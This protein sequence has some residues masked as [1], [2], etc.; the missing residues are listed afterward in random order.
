M[1]D[2]LSTSVSGLLAFQKALN[3]TSNNISNVATP[4]YSVENANFTEQP[5]QAFS[6]GYIGSGVNVQSVTRAYDEL[7][8]GQVRSSQSSYSSFNTYATQASQID[9]MLSDSSTGLTASLQSFVNA[10]QTVANSPSS[11]AQRQVLLSQAQSLTQQMQNYSSQ[12][13]TYSAGVESQIS[14]SVTQIN[15]LSAGIANLNGQIATGLASTGQ[16]PNS[17]MDQRDQMIDQLSQYV[18]V[19]TATQADGSMNVYIGSGQPL[20]TG[21][22]ST[23]LSAIQD[24]YNASVHDIG[25]ATGGGT[26]D[27]TSNISGGSLGGLL[28][29]RSQVLQPVQNTLGQF[30]V[31]LASI[32]NQAQQAGMDL[33]GAAGKPMFAVGPVLTAPSSAN[34]GTS[35]IAVTRTDLS[36]LTA[37]DYTLRQTGGAWQLTDE[38]TG[39]AV[40]MTGT[41]TAADPFKAAGISIVVGGGA[42]ANGDSFLIQPTAGAAAG[43]SVLLTSPTQ[44]A[45]ASSI[46]TTPAA[47][48]TGTG[49]VSSSAVTDPTTWVPGTYTI[50]FTSATQYQVT[51]VGGA[52]ISN[53]T[54]TS[55]SP[56]TFNGG[57]VTLTGAPATG[58][59]FTVGAAG[60]SNTGDNGNAFA[61]IDALSASQLNGGTTSLTNVANNLVSQVGVQTQQ[62]QANASAQK[63]VNAS[64]V[65]TRNNLSGVN[66]DEEAAKMVQFQQAYSACA[67]L[68]QASNTMFNALLSAVHG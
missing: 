51:D 6:T 42:A 16:T 10:V 65:D 39:Q 5:G 33:T 45:A 31:G 25:I 32:V 64:A 15:T 46:Q 61:M 49:A 57:S 27:I 62:A 43:L 58:D 21:S 35:T 9:N 47:A 59:S 29:V 48:N 34:T 30:S 18:T 11:T 54:Y 3:V 14:A 63:S 12:L 52:V 2:L 66:L 20:V 67:Q 60:A 22:S 23:Q 55:G 56:I 7:L 38:T 37:D 8:A 41:G 44:I 53:G 1:S 13:S 19:N 24:P 36:S 26:A 17:L 28:A 40:T 68:I 50:S 4:G